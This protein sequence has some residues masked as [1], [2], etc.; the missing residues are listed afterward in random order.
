ML[1][2]SET[3]MKK[4]AETGRSGGAFWHFFDKTLQ[5]PIRE[6]RKLD[7]NTGRLGWPAGSGVGLE[8]PSWNPPLAYTHAP[9]CLPFCRCCYLS[10]LFYGKWSSSHLVIKLFPISLTITKTITFPITISSHRTCNKIFL[11]FLFCHS[12]V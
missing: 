7:V 6:I 10:N 1:A 12:Q 2:G 11:S 9:P 8:D 4:T 3:E 5:L